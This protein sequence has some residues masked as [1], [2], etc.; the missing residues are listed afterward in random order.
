M[1]EHIYDPA[2]VEQRWQKYWDD[3]GTNQID[4]RAAKNPYYV[5]MMFPYPSAEGL[6]VGNVYAFTGA[7]VTGRHRRLRGYDV[8]EPIGFDAFG[9]HSENFAMKINRHP[10]E[11][12]PANIANFTRQLRMMGLM[13]DWR[14]SVDT[15]SPDYYKW[16]QWIFL[17][18]YKAGLAYRDE[19][20]V[21]F[22]PDC[23]TVIADEQVIDGKCERHPD[24]EVQRR[25]LPSWFFRITNFADRLDK[26]LDWIDWSEKTKLAQKNW[27]GRSEG[28]EVDFQVQGRNERIRV[29]TTR[30]DTLFGATFMVLAVDHP[31]VDAIAGT[32]E[33]DAIAK[34]REACAS[35]PQDASAPV[36]A[37]SK[38]GVFI[39]ANAI[40]P[41]NGAAIPIYISDYVLSGYGTG[42][43]MAVP[44][45]DERDFEFAEKFGLPIRCVISPDAA[46]LADFRLPD[47]I[48]RDS[49]DSEALREEILRGQTCWSGAG[50]AVNSSNSEVSLDGLAVGAAKARITQ[51]LESKNL[52]KAKTTFRLRDW[53]IS[54]QRYW[55][56]PIPVLY[57]EDGNIHPVPEDQLPVTLPPIRDFRPKG[58]GRGPLANVPEWMN[59][60]I[61][62]RKY[63]RETDVMDNFLD[64]AWYY[65][66]YVS[67]DDDKRPYDPELIRKWLPLDVYIGGNEHAVLHLLYTRF[68]CMALDH[69][70]ALKMGNRPGMT[71]GAEPFRKLRSHGLLIKEGSKM[72]K[73]KGNVVNP[74]EYVEKWGADTLRLYLMF[75]GPYQ[76]GG[77]FR[78]TDIVGMR[79]FLNRLYTW[80]H[81][82]TQPVVANDTLPKPLLVKTHQ[83]IKK[84]REDI[85]ALSYNTAISAIMEL[86]NAAKDALQT[87]DFIRESLIVMLA[88]LAP[89]FAE[90]IWQGALRKP[91]SIWKSARY[92]DHIEELTRLDEIEIVLQVGGRIRDKIVVPRDASKEALEAKALASD[93]VRAAM[94]GA[95]V[96]KVIVVPGRLVNVI[97]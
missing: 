66:R 1:S 41:V 91:E 55:G 50:V 71:D 56:P 5:L 28:A 31:L 32:R 14:R 19:K 74:D 24:T 62:G 45:H 60:E 80:Y 16:T 73:S 10:A 26:N 34:Y 9:I 21:N 33:R 78:D 29:Y 75:L 65:L 36:S 15:T 61:N 89:H 77:D 94:A 67:T 93:K 88:P 39:G 22:C 13:Y 92:P 47:P 79:R 85:D 52:G 42:A 3:H 46:A 49:H 53:G 18:L 8:F 38:T 59:V 97:I 63:R 70:G 51:W 37:L 27:I 7:D 43:I 87:S 90:E 17:Q 96:K 84:V 86:L 30:P 35:A 4:L 58:D 72:S 54:R 48:S 82:S 81:E 44:A 40:N 2:V 6:H 20:E 12:I 95:A 76:Q 57:D 23:G 68:I 69:A 11:L 64:S 25:K 83:T